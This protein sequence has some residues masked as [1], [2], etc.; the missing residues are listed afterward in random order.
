VGSDLA[1]LGADHHPLVID[2]VVQRL[3]PEVVPEADHAAAGLDR[4]RHEVAEQLLC[5]PLARP[6]V[7]G[8]QQLDVRRGRG[9]ARPPQPAHHLGAVVEARVGDEPGPVPA[10]VGL[11]LEPRF[12]RGVQPAG[13]DGDVVPRGDL[14]P[15]GR[16]VQ[17]RVP[18]H[19][20]YPGRD[21]LTGPPDHHGEPGH[22]AGSL[23]AR[24][25]QQGLDLAAG[26]VEPRGRVVV[27]QPDD[28][29]RPG[30][31]QHAIDQ[32]LPLGTGVEVERVPEELDA[33][34]SGR[35]R[36]QGRLAGT[37]VRSVPE[38]HEGEQRG[39]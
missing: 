18:H 7:P 16:A 13:H 25:R 9:G 6:L 39:V 26:Q 3:H 36:T 31:R 35:Q 32:L 33:G 4:D 8:R 22:Q 34:R 23:A 28:R 1:Q 37:A 29:A 30:Q 5:G 2:P 19:I 12:R 11:A 17:Q 15:V 27:G 21:R 14:D 10:L 20:D 24:G 38:R